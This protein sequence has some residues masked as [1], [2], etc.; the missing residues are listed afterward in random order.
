[1]KICSNNISP[2]IRQM[3][4]EKKKIWYEKSQECWQFSTGK[5]VKASSSSFISCFFSFLCRSRGNKNWSSPG[6]C[7]LPES[8]MQIHGRKSTYASTQSFVSTD[9]PR[10]KQWAV[11]ED[12]N[13]VNQ[14]IQLT[15]VIYW[16][17]TICRVRGL[18]YEDPRKGPQSAGSHPMGLLFNNN[19]S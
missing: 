14:S 15:Q 8:W 2:E 9:L 16:I 11:M 7:V 19:Y 12:K 13:R 5:K 4:E 18:R 6:K 17:F 3:V 1:M 10:Y